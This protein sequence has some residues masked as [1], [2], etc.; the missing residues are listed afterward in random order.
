[1]NNQIL[2]FFTLHRQIFGTCPNPECG[3]IF[4]LSD[5][6][7]YLRRRPLADWM[8]AL[9]RE[10]ERLGRLEEKLAA[11]EREVREKAREAGR[12]PRPAE[13]FEVPGDPGMP[14]PRRQDREA[15]ADEEPDRPVHAGD[16]GVAVPDRQA[17][18]GAE[19]VLEVD[20][21]EG[22]L[23]RHVRPREPARPH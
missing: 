4:R 16:D 18:P 2:D 22:G 1:M 12:R 5:C 11:R 20:D 14:V 10:E 21:Q 7:V 13:L 3:S 8:D 17:A 19:I 23:P 9:N 6:H 15:A